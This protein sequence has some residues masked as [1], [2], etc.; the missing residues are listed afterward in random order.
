VRVA[1]DIASD[2]DGPGAKDSLRNISEDLGELEQ[3]FGD[4]LTLARFELAEGRRAQLQN[5][6]RMELLEPGELVAKAAA[7]FRAAHPSRVLKL[8]LE[9]PLP[10]IRGDSR[11]LRRVLENLLENGRKYSEPRSELVLKAHRVGDE[12]LMEIADAGIGIDAADLPHVFTP[13]FRAERSR[14][15]ATGGVGLGLTLALRIAEAHG[16][17][18]QLS[19]TRGVGT[20]AS[21][22]VPV[23][24]ASEAAPPATPAVR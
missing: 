6:L 10:R 19:S 18:L 21:L 4:V 13:F 23:L 2:F 15:R 20:T 8:H 12:L 7:R 24:G 5:L 16:G 11:L 1:L 9:E 14:S 3:L 22:R 17:T